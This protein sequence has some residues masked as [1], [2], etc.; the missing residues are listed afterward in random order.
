L[1]ASTCAACHTGE[2]ASL[3]VKRVAPDP[4]TLLPKD[5]KD[6]FKITI[7]EK[8]Y[9]AATI[10]HTDIARKLTE[11]VNKSWLAKYFHKSETTLCAGCHH[12]TP[13][14]K[15]KPVPA[16]VNCHSARSDP[17]ARVPTLLGAYHQQC[18]GCHKRMGHPEQRMPQDCAGCHKEKKKG[19]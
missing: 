5:L 12:A 7:L 10:K 6:E 15:N 14:E 18:L 13:I 19:T 4:A 3:D 17:S 11:V 16:C 1:D 8:E 9:D 2:L